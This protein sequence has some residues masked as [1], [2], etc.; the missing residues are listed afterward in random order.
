MGELDAFMCLT[1]Y[2]HVSSYMQSIRVLEEQN[3]IYDQ[4]QNWTTDHRPLT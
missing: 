4:T 1:M 3:H 2:I